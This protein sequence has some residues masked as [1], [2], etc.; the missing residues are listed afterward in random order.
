M[1]SPRNHEVAGV[2]AHLIVYQKNR[3]TNGLNSQ[4]VGQLYPKFD[5][6]IKMFTPPGFKKSTLHT[7]LPAPLLQSA[8]NEV[9]NNLMTPPG[10][11]LLVALA[12]ASLTTQGLVDV[13]LPTGKE[14]A[15]ALMLL[16]VADSGERKTAVE[17]IFFKAIRQM[18]EL[19]R[20]RFEADS[21]RYRRDYEIWKVTGDVK[22]KKLKRKIEKGECSE[23]EAEELNLH[24]ESEPAP[25]TLFKMLFEDS[26]L[27]ALYQGL[28]DVPSA[29]LS[30]SE[31]G[32]VLS[33]PLFS[34]QTKLNAFWSGSPVPVDRI[35]SGSF[36]LAG[37]RLTVLV[38]AQPSLLKDFIAEKGDKARGSGLLARMLVCKT[39]TTQ[40]MRFIENTTVSWEHSDR[41]NVRVMEL[42][43]KNFEALKTGGFQKP[44]LK[45][46]PDAEVEWLNF[47][48]MVERNMQFNSC[49]A[50]AR[51]HASK[52]PE[53][54][55]RVAAVL[56]HFEGL[57]GDISLE[58]LRAAIHVVGSLSSDF[59]DMFVEPPEFREAEVLN[60]WLSQKYRSIN[61]RYVAK[62]MVRRFCPNAMRNTALLDHILG[63]L[64][65]DGKVALLRKN[66]TVFVDVMPWMGLSTANN[67]AV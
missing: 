39:G 20:A 49:Y 56:H 31:G 11:A 14:I 5:E 57:E 27:P 45:F 47:Y 6:E 25:P 24:L 2:Q 64:V 67:D 21:V 41:F 62:T 15:I 32:G 30:S 60:D 54:V 52:I 8:V 35:S 50:N 26:T 58:I 28:K 66:K 42:M 16:I 33:G 22:K 40:G 53:N 3:M 61:N 48:N 63:I 36:V 43:E 17:A 1:V 9:T 29:C 65:R 55:A 18:E 12:A 19:C 34:E 46:S 44:V 37:V 38:M 23:K 7:N 13:K 59:L 4:A 10:M 51:D